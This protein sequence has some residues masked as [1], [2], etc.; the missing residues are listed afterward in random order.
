MPA[1]ENQNQNFYLPF[2]CIIVFV[3]TI[4]ERSPLSPM[5]CCSRHFVCACANFF[6]PF[7]L[8]SWLKVLGQFTADDFTGSFSKDQ[9]NASPPPPPV[10]IDE[11][12]EKKKNRKKKKENNLDN[13]FRKPSFQAFFASKSSI[14]QLKFRQDRY[15]H[16]V[17]R[18][19]FYTNK[20]LKKLSIVRSF[21]LTTSDLLF[22]DSFIFFQHC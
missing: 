4:H 10:N 1:T 12:L 20:T 11:N 6:E 15:S 3:C 19:T 22:T 8:Q 17:P 14:L 7:S 21:F 16:F 9:G 5:I 13:S 18:I 2:R